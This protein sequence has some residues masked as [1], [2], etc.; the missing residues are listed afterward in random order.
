MSLIPRRD[1]PRSGGFVLTPDVAGLFAD[2][3]FFAE[4]GATLSD[5]TAFTNVSA[6]ILRALYLRTSRPMPIVLAQV[7]R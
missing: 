3:E 5:I 7:D 4:N 6:Q 2:V 1:R